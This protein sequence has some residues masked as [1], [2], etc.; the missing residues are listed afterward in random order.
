MKSCI[1]VGQVRHRRL[2]PVKHAFQYPLFMMFLDLDELPDIFQKYWFWSYQKKNIASFQTKDY[3][4]NKSVDLSDDVR[5][6]VKQK[7]GE[8]PTGPVRLLTH[9]KYF[10]H[11]FNPVSFYYC[12][13]SD[14]QTLHSIVAEITNTPWNEAY[15]YVLKVNSEVNTMYRFE[16]GKNFHVSPFNKMQQDYDWRL[17]LPTE[18]LN[19]H[20]NVIE[21]EIKVF[22]A[23]MRL[24]KQSINSK[25]LALCLL[26]FP[27]MT[28]KIVFN[29]YYQ[30]F[31][32]W[33]KRSPVYDHPNKKPGKEAP[34]QAN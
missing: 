5:D 2:S 26:R 8:L 18:N 15:S 13:E 30:A 27:L 34:E 6:L 23:T 9:M 4:G 17:K 7:T 14:G 24:K 19:V 29:I 1:Y 10:G 16:F 28:V 11:V 25:N 31:K 21:D 12:Y 20:M 32:L 33:I 22:D 3:M